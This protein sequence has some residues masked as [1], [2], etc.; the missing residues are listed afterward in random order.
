MS[1][2]CLR[3]EN[4]IKS[5]GE[6]SARQEALR[7]VSVSVNAGEFLAIRGPSGCGKSTLLHILGAMDRPTDGRV[8]LN[9]RRLD[10]LKPDELAMIRRRHIGF[11]FQAF[12]LLPGQP[13]TCSFPRSTRPGLRCAGKCQHQALW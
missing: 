2:A 12:N 8:W 9:G 5:Y 11:I 3:A 6:E 13:R 7:G 10:N 4:L 1:Q